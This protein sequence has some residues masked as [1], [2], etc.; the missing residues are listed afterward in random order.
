L[1][2][3]QGIASISGIV[4]AAIIGVATKELIGYVVSKIRKRTKAWDNPDY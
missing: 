3:N 4:T 2:N 1:E